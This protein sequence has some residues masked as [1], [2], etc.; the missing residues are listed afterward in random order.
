[1]ELSSETRKTTL[2]RLAAHALKAK[3]KS[4]HKEKINLRMGMGSGA[5]ETLKEQAVNYAPPESL[6]GGVFEKL[7]LSGKPQFFKLSHFSG[8]LTGQIA[9]LS[10]VL[11]EMKQLPRLIL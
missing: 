3:A 9:G 6:P 10:A 2:G 8:H 4:A 5:I 11:P 7:S 1:M